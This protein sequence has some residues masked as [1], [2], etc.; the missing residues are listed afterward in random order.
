MASE[1]TAE[2]SGSAGAGLP[3]TPSSA[4]AIE[5][6]S[7]DTA[8]QDADAAT[9]SQD[10]LTVVEGIG[11]KISSILQA[12]GITTFQQLSE[13]TPDELRQ[14]MRAAGIRVADPSTWPEQAAFA[15]A[16]DWD[17]LRELQSRLIAGR[18]VE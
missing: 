1:A 3:S 18:R 5:A 15:A 10:D 12:A 16:D 13:A 14:K 7:P 11:P 8:Q 2:D 9:P 6:V 17:G 4:E